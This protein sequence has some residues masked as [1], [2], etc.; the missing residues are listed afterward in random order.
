MPHGHKTTEDLLN[1]FNQ[2]RTKNKGWDKENRTKAHGWHI[3]PSLM[4]ISLVPIHHVFFF[5]SNGLWKRNP[6]PIIFLL[7][8]WWLQRDTE[9][10]PGLFKRCF[11]KEILRSEVVVMDVGVHPHTPSCPQHFLCMDPPYNIFIYIIVKRNN[12]TS[13]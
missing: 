10:G 8:R 9:S 7:L 1:F 13:R 4:S 2:N 12:F 6:Y 3:Y 5:S 11:S